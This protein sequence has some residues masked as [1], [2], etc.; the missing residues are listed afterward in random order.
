MFERMAFRGKN[1]SP[2]SEVMLFAGG[3]SNNTGHWVCLAQHSSIHWVQLILRPSQQTVRGR[4]WSHCWHRVLSNLSLTLW[5]VFTTEETWLCSSFRAV[6]S[7]EFKEL[8]KSEKEG[9]LYICPKYT[10]LVY[11]CVYIYMD[12]YAYMNTINAYFYRV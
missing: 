3:P 4:G 11:V 8:S 10:K 1:S 7:Q 9:N 2:G 12:I 6:K 5:D